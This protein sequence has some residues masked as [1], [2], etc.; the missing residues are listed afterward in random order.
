MVRLSDPPVTVTH[1]NDHHLGRWV[2]AMRAAGLSTRTVEERSRLIHR[3]GADTQIAAHA[4]TTDDI[5]AWL[6]AMTDISA[7]SKATYQAT[8]RAW[9]RWLVMRGIRDDDPTMRLMSVKVPRREARP[10]TTEQLQRLLASNLRRR[11]RMMVLL[12]AY[13]G[14]R[15]SEIAKLRA[16]DIDAIGNTLRIRKGKGAKDATLPLHPLVAAQ[17]RRLPRRGY[18]FQS[19]RNQFEPIDRCSVSDVV[20]RAMHRVGIGASAHQLRH[21]YGTELTRA[22]VPTRV[23]QEL[24]RHSSIQTTQIYTQVDSAQQA[25]AIARLPRVA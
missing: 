21:W 17:A 7:S 8:L 2:T 4:L 12:G 16:T 25:D 23:V 10:L 1:M 15:T 20:R 5:E 9:S 6:G 22:G 13:Q 19:Y 11:T 24:M 3:I 14:L 18:L